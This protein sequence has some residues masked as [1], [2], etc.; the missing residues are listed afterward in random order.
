MAERR[1]TAPR[2][3]RR[4]NPH[5]RRAVGCDSGSEGRHATCAHGCS[6]PTGDPRVRSSSVRRPLGQRV[7]SPPHRRSTRRCHAPSPR[8]RT[9]RAESEELPPR[10]PRAT[11]AS[12]AATLGASARGAS[13]RPRYV[14]PPSTPGDDGQRR[15]GV[16]RVASPGLRRALRS[17]ALPPQ[18]VPCL[19]AAAFEDVHDR[20]P[21]RSPGDEDVVA[22]PRR[23]RT[24]PVARP[25]RQAGPVREPVSG[26]GPSGRSAPAPR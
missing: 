17:V 1:P 19:G 12:R 2:S 18:P 3:H 4:L 5:D 9:S 22:A 13:R 16:Q 24:R 11:G 14:Q 21:A 10:S 25:R 15:H 7:R 6:R 8:A 23:A 20:Q 26:R